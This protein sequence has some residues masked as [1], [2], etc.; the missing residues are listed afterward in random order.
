MSR[1]E[2]IVDSQ[3]QKEQLNK[4]EE[5]EKKED[6]VEDEYEK[7]QKNDFYQQ[8]FYA[9]RPVPTIRSTT[10]I[11][12]TLGIIF[13]ALGIVI[14]IY[15]NEINEV[16]KRYDNEC[17]SELCEIK[18]TIDKKI[19][20]DVM[21]YYE[22]DDFYQNH[23][24]Y[25]KSRSEDQINGKDISLKKM[26]KSGDCDP[27]I[28]NSEMGVSKSVNDK[29]LSSDDIAIPCGLIA[30]SYFK[31]TFELYDDNNNIIEIDEKNIAW[32]A[33]KKLKFKNIDL[34]KQWIDMTDEHFI[35]WMRTSGLPN[36]RKL[37]GR[38]HQDLEPGDYKVKINNVFDVS[39]F[40]GKKIFILTNVNIF[41]GKNKFLA[42][43]YIIVGLICIVLAIVFIIGY[44]HQL[45]LQKKVK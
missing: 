29:D 40:G 13:L 41:G 35:V 12:I 39:Q 8:R 15:S 33:D 4:K 10:V 27:V 11:F 28:T 5:S 3:S 24:R 1:D 36:F 37:W 44:K 32:N 18:I 38:I 25:V 2:N 30:K 17:S 22:I 16:K 6:E 20:K 14:L 45:N 26:K 43:G 19:K 34:D 21:V 7:L 31:D 23:R 42:V 9:W